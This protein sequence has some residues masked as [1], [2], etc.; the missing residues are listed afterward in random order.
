MESPHD[1]TA[2]RRD[3]NEAD[4]FLV[5]HAD[6]DQNGLVN[7]TTVIIMGDPVRDAA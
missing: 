3:L 5:I 4:N 1:C 6:P 7:G 2:L